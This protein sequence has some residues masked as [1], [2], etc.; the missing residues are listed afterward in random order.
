MSRITDE[1]MGHADDN[2][3]IEE[4]DNP[5]PDWWV[6]LFVVT[7]LWGIGYALN[8]HV[9]AQDSQLKRYDVQMAAAEQR[10][11][12]SD[13]AVAL[14]F[15][16]ATLAE[17]KEVFVQTCQACHME[18]GVGGP[19]GPS[20]VDAEWLHGSDPEQIRATITDGVTEKGMPAW[21]QILGPE[22]VRKVAAYVV[23]LG[24]NASAQPTAAADPP[25]EAPA[26]EPAA[27][28]PD[29]PEPDLSTLSEDQ[30]RAYLMERGKRI[31]ET[32]ETGLACTTCHQAT[33]QGVAGAFPPLVGQKTHMGDCVNHATLI[34]DGLSGE[35]EVDGV[36]YNGVMMGQRDQLNDLQ[37]AAVISYV[38]NSWGN[39]Y[40]LCSPEDVA[41]ARAR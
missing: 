13:V 23:E 36:T 37:I 27:E 14:A 29:E 8:F 41:T 34:L 7:V 40:G 16:E 15:D 30:R 39:D 2:D 24:R 6:G 28:A 18:E 26:E 9:V 22:K 20:L 5:L 10:W 35:I 32:G 25:S 3:G 19:I 11:P 21:G 4:Y 1:I 33:G 38:R 12:E 31:Y 17:G